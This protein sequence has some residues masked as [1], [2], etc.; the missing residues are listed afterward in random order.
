MA[1][2]SPSR[3]ASLVASMPAVKTTMTVPAKNRP[4]W[5]GVKP[6]PS[7][8]H[9][10]RCGK[11]REQAA[12]DQADGRGGNDEAAV[13]DQAEIVFGNRQRIERRPRRMMGL[14]EH[15]G[16]GSRADHGEHS[17]KDEL[18]TP[19]EIVIERAAEQRREAGRCRHRDHDQR[20]GAAERRAGEQVA[21]DGA[22]QHRGRAGAG[23][24]DDAADQQAGKIGGEAAPDAAGEEHRKACQHRPAP[25]VAIGDRPDHELAEREYREEHG[26]RRRHF[27][28]RHPQRRRHLRQRRQQDVGRQRSGRGQRGEHGDLQEGRGD[29]RAGSCVDRYGL[30]GHGSSRLIEYRMICII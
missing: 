6:M 14:A 24:L 8:K 18:G 25:A 12:H 9:A 1:R 10:G 3:G 16:I 30:V 27:G 13:G 23:G 17:D 19:A 29:L 26:D 15:R 2:S 7:I 22:R 4:S 5:I 28:G 11:Y 21:G 20:H